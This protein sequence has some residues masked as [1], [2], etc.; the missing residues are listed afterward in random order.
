MAVAYNANAQ[1]DNSTICASHT[2]STVS[3]N[4]K[5][6]GDS[7]VRKVIFEGKQSTSQ[8]EVRV[9]RRG[10]IISNTDTLQWYDVK[11]TEYSKGAPDSATTQYI[12]SA[13]YHIDGTGYK[14]K[15]YDR[16]RKTLATVTIM[17]LGGKLEYGKYNGKE[18]QELFTNLLKK[19][20]KLGYDDKMARY[21]AGLAL[22]DLKNMGTANFMN[23]IAQ[24]GKGE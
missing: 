1:S 20:R 9:S 6:V 10:G 17:Q 5:A 7:A 22:R 18:S 3:A 14:L 13:Q 12:I 21:L 11:F 16:T 24:R 4:P 8:G 15:I 23:Y 19:F 2:V